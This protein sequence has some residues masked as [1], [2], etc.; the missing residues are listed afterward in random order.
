VFENK[1]A[2]TMKYHLQV[3]YYPNNTGIPVGTADDPSFFL[4]EMHYDNPTLK[5]G[6]NMFITR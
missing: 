5:S 2:L 1:N 4:M 6:I 3:Y